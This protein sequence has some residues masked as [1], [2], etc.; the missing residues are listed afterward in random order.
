[1]VSKRINPLTQLFFCRG[2]FNKDGTKRFWGYRNFIKK[3]GFFSEVWLITEDFGSAKLSAHN[4]QKSASLENRMANL[5]KRKNLKT[6]QVYRPGE[7]NTHG[8]FFI[9]YAKT[10]K[11]S[12]G[13]CGESWGSKDA[14]IRARVHLTLGKL[15]KRASFKKIPV[16]VD[17][18][19]L[20]SIFPDDMKCPILKM[21]MKF[22]GERS[23]SPSLDRLVPEKG[24]VQGNIAWVSLLANTVKDQRTPKELRLIADWIEKQPI[25]QLYS[26]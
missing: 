24:Y 20:V 11:T 17:I 21:E 1:M 12:D 19:Y 8:Q 2:D 15:K 9:G 25:Y 10:K 26:S 3:D 4:R 23:S 14:Y 13:Y 18:D 16:T 6:G 22:G 7:R 5:P